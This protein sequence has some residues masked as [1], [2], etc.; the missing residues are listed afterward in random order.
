MPNTSLSLQPT[1]EEVDAP[2]DDS[3]PLDQLNDIPAVP[4]IF[5]ESSEADE[6]RARD[7]ENDE[8]SGMSQLK[9]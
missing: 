3:P 9:E 5:G 7:S 1:A 8:R 2:E 6:N 4:S